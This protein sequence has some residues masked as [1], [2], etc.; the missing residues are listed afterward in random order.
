MMNDSSLLTGLIEGLSILVLKQEKFSQ[1]FR[2]VGTLPE[3]IR[4]MT[5]DAQSKEAYLS[6]LLASPFLQHFLIEVHEFFA[7]QSQGKLISGMWSER[8]SDH[9]DHEFEAIAV[10]G[11][12]D[13]LLLIRRIEHGGI[14]VQNVLQT[15]RERGL[16]HHRSIVK[17]QKIQ[18]VLGDQLEQSEQ[19]RDDLVAILD[20]LRLGTIMTNQQGQITFVSRAV[21]QLLNR[22]EPDLIG[23]HWRSFLFFQMNKEL[24]SK[25]CWI[26]L[27]GN[28]RKCHLWSNRKRG[29]VFHSKSMFKKTHGIQTGRSFFCMM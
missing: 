9:R 16:Q 4:M 18:Q 11:L 17:Q 15:A 7:S 1:D 12:E 27:L 24:K 8:G 29:D 2:P 21:P 5:G 10:A 6:A 19:L 14:D 3:W 25:Q 28:E 26:V 22:A 13:N 20:R 23:C